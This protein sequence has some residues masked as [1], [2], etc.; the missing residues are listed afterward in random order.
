MLLFAA[1]GLGAYLFY[2]WFLA[3]SAPQKRAP[4]YAGPPL[5]ASAAR[6]LD[7]E[8]LHR[9]DHAARQKLYAA[10]QT[11]EWDMA[12]SIE[13][14]PLAE[15]R[16]LALRRLRVLFERRCVDVRDLERDPHAF[17]AAHEVACLTDASTAT[18]LTVAANLM[19][20]TVL[21]LG[22]KR[23]DKLIDKINKM[24]V[25]GWC[26]ACGGWWWGVGG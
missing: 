2:K 10:V 6:A 21:A 19:G 11:P 14:L 22:S 15:Q 3:P 23:H 12:L 24:E 26:S 4:L 8:V 5:Q 16:A 13:T 7:A 1:L 25:I 9:C 17:F 18:K 20:G